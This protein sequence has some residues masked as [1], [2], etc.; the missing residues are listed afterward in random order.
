L[1]EEIDF[2]LEYI[3]SHI[4]LHL[5]IILRCAVYYLL[6]VVLCLLWPWRTP[7]ED[8]PPEGIVLMSLLTVMT[9]PMIHTHVTQLATGFMWDIT[10]ALC[11]FVEIVLPIALICHVAR[12]TL[13]FIPE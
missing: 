1:G 6:F 3:I 7:K 9:F 5:T 4:L 12:P 11:I 2:F 13:Q 10:L 8:V